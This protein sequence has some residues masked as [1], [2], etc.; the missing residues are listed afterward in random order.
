M[1]VQ[2]NSSKRTQG[3]RRENQLS[4][5]EIAEPFQ[6]IV[7]ARVGGGIRIR[8]WPLDMEENEIFIEINQVRPEQRGHRD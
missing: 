2:D 3:A 7:F 8:C 5:G 1:N 4:P 6:R